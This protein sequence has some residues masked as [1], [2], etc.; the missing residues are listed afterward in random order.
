M[1]LPASVPEQLYYVYGI[2]VC[3]EPEIRSYGKVSYRKS[4]GMHETGEDNLFVDCLV[5]SVNIG[6]VG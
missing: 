2:H 6:M 4:K 1:E 5:N 3:S